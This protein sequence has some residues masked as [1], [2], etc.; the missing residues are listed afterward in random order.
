MVDL[1][2]QATC[3]P[4][5]SKVYSFDVADMEPL[6]EAEIDAR[7]ARRSVFG[8]AWTWAVTYLLLIPVFAIIYASLPA[9]SFH[10]SNLQ[11]E[12]S[13]QADTVA[14]EQ[15]LADSIRSNALTTP[16]QYS[17]FSVAL[18]KASLSVTVLP[19]QP[20]GLF[21]IEIQGAVSGIQDRPRQTSHPETLSSHFVETVNIHIT[22][23]VTTLPSRPSVVRGL[24][25]QYLYDI[26][27][28]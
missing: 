7:P 6:P 9:G 21:Y 2:N 10:D 23:P 5:R 26:R 11:Y 17:S 12:S 1:L 16:W 24:K 3:S 19:P 20:D 15:T 25:M 4:L 18:N 14:L 22:N 13:F 28:P 8:R 27:Y